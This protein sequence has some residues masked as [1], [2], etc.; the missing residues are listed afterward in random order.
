M[1]KRK[2]FLFT[3]LFPE[4]W[5][6]PSFP[7]W[8]ALWSW[9]QSLPLDCRRSAKESDKLNVQHNTGHLWET[10]SGICFGNS[11]TS[12]F[13]SIL[14]FCI[15]LVLWK[16]RLVSKYKREIWKADE[17]DSAE[18]CELRPRASSASPWSWWKRR[19]IQN[20][21]G[22]GVVIWSLSWRWDQF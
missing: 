22:L 3:P 15:G 8:S 4:Q 18:V 21:D 16:Y 6:A 2:N 19:H 14:A 1:K 20:R 10:G 5:Y 11:S 9:N 7:L 13:S 12:E 17:E